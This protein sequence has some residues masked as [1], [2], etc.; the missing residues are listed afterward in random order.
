MVTQPW[1]RELILEVWELVMTWETISKGLKTIFYFIV[2][3]QDEDV[4]LSCETRFW[5]DS[6][7]AKQVIAA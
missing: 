2:G 4:N 6:I 3:G 7:D 5:A 1:V